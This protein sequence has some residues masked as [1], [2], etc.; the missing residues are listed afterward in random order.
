MVLLELSSWVSVVGEGGNS[1]DLASNVVGIEGVVL[2]I[3]CVCVCVG[4]G[5]ERVA[6]LVGVLATTVRVRG[7]VVLVSEIKLS[8]SVDIIGLK[9]VHP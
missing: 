8:W 6:V 7:A 2:S 3:V 1:V 4:V 5:V 9:E